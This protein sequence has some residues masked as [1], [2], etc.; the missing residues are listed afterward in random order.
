[1]GGAL[2][3]TDGTTVSPVS[4]QA[5]S[6]SRTPVSLAG[7]AVGHR[8]RAVTPRANL[9]ASGKPSARLYPPGQASGAPAVRGPPE[10]LVTAPK[11]GPPPTM[12]VHEAVVA[13]EAAARVQFTAI[14]TDRHFRTNQH[15]DQYEVISLSKFLQAKS[16]N[17]AHYLFCIDPMQ[18]QKVVERLKDRPGLA[19]HRRTA[20]FVV[21]DGSSTNLPG[22]MVPVEVHS[23]PPGTCVWKGLDP[24]GAEFPL[25]PISATLRVFAEAESKRCVL[26]SLASSQVLKVKAGIHQ[27][28][29]SM[30]LDT[31]ASANFISGK[32]ARA[33]DLP[34][35]PD[36][37]GLQVVM[38]DGSSASITGTVITPVCIGR[39]RAKRVSS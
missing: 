32:L 5:V 17:H 19:E 4:G 38:G 15:A 30:L 31:G 33:L 26:N 39:Y 1:L 6:E 21:S 20:H 8:D 18:I 35:T 37:Q 13:L 24:K 10:P 7:L 34:L 3:A 2:E 22:L 9:I 14:V 11:P 12:L 28:A 29:I 16:L 27:A 25:P 36:S 23:F